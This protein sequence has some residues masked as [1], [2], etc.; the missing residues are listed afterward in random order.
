MCYDNGKTNEACARSYSLS[1]L[2][3]HTG[4][5]SCT[6]TLIVVV[7]SCSVLLLVNHVAASGEVCVIAREMKGFLSLLYVCLGVGCTFICPCLYFV[8]WVKF[9]PSS[10]GGRA[11]AFGGGCIMMAFGG[12]W[13]YLMLLHS[14]LTAG[15]YQ[16]GYAGWGMAYFFLLLIVFSV[17]MVVVDG[18]TAGI[19]LGIT[20]VFFAI[21]IAAVYAKSWR[22]Q[23]P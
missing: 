19:T 4:M 22:Q 3:S 21:M 2:I 12:M 7:A 13:L 18:S 1:W 10:I 9:P 6:L 16:L 14:K 23:K 5:I 15:H 8:F 17:T 20:S 11:F